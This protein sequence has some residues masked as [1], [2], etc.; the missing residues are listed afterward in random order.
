MAP[1]DF[2]KELQKRWGSR[3]IK[4]REQVWTR[5]SARLEQEGPVLRRGPKPWMFMAAASVVLLMGFL[6]FRE[7]V[8][9]L[10]SLPPVVRTPT[11]EPPIGVLPSPVQHTRSDAPEAEAGSLADSYSE[12]AHARP[13]EKN[14]IRV[15][16]PDQP[17]VSDQA[18]VPLLAEN[19]ENGIP[20]EAHDAA[21]LA[22]PPA[23]AGAVPGP[24]GALEAEIEALLKNAREGIGQQNQAET[25]SPVDARALLDR[26]EDELDQT[27]REKI[28]EK[29]KSG[30]TRSRTGVVNRD[31]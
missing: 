26:A 23:N 25:L 20:E 30:V 9:K 17:Q 2:E 10:P 6:L 24:E 21:D 3:E 29:L 15:A 8:E 11:V 13:S 5:L 7:P 16:G 14:E 4:P 31:K 18:A 28:M 27:F 1:I 12:P 19:G 22:A